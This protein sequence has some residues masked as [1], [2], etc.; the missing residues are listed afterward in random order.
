[1]VKP[2]IAK[3]PSVKYVVPD[4][5]ESDKL[6]VSIALYYSNFQWIA[7]GIETDKFQQIHCRGAIWSALSIL[8]NTDLG[9]NGVKVYFH[10]EDVMYDKAK[11]IFDE[12]SVPEEYIRKI[13]VPG[14]SD[15]NVGDV[16]YGK[17][18]IAFLDEEI[19]ADI[20]MIPDSDAFVCTTGKPLEWYDILTSDNFVNHPSSFEIELGSF[21]YDFWAKKC[22]HAAGFAYDENIP[23][24]VQERQAY[25][26]LGISY[27]KNFHEI[28]RTFNMPMPDTDELEH[29]SSEKVVRPTLHNA[30]KTIPT[31][32][33]LREIIEKNIHRCYQSKWILGMYGVENKIINMSNELN[34]RMFNHREDYESSQDENYIHHVIFGA[35]QCDNFFDRFYSDIT[36]NM[37][38]QPLQPQKLE[39]LEQH[40]N[41][42]DTEEPLQMLDKK[43][44]FS[45]LDDIKFIEP[46]VKPNNLLS[47]SIPLFECGHSKS[48]NKNQYLDTYNDNY[49]KA[50]M[51]SAMSIIWNSDIGENGVKVYFHIEDS[52]IDVVL[53][54]LQKQGVPDQYIR[55]ISLPNTYQYNPELPYTPFGKKY[56]WVYDEEINTDLVN[57]LSSDV[58]LCTKNNKAELYRDLTSPILRESI[59]VAYFKLIRFNYAY[60]LREYITT[61]GITR[62]Y[63]DKSGWIVPRAN[64]NESVNIINPEEIE[65]VC[66]EQYGF[67]YNLKETIQASDYVLR[68]R[69]DSQM[70]Q[71]PI[72]SDFADIV[73]EHGYN[74]Y[75]DEG[76]FSMYFLS[77]SIS[78]IV[79][80]DALGIDIFNSQDQ[81]NS[82]TSTYFAHYMDSDSN[83][84]HPCYID[85]YKSMM[86]IFH[87]IHR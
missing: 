19:N 26:T 65:R 5:E 84:Q 34:I 68:P 85:F 59:A 4:V 76:L 78:P 12:F 54:Y 86:R 40:I 37:P 61:S 70:T 53:P 56:M 62:S 81:Y 14:E 74:C 49:T 42:N 55:I 9:A 57:V 67:K 83:P 31:R 46:D 72:N 58:F 30:F 33:P 3:L 32:H 17:N 48:L 20:L 13:T 50:A 11:P 15:P 80:N 87:N 29:H 43:T 63:L 38:I 66:F 25:Q 27:P 71:M 16:H 2:H 77:E 7:G 18:Y 41:R 10:I 52:I 82:S 73:R 39:V 6:A 28:Y 75:N 35:D 1:M 22:C 8:H 24:A 79:L 23:A 69:V 60:K 36:R 45:N 64:I 51:W 47:F 44:Y 21:A